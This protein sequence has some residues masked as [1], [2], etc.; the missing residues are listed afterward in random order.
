[1]CYMSDPAEMLTELTQVAAEAE[2]LRAQAG[3]SLRQAVRQAAD[4]GLT[5]QQIAHAIG[6]S[7][8][9]VSRLIKTHRA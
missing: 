7:Q 2:R 3:E 8:P 9:E 1:M 5:Q 6:R 4:S